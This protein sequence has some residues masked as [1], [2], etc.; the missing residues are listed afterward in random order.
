MSFLNAAAF[1]F[2]A[3]IPVVVVLYLL[4]RKRTY[5]AVSST[6]LWQRFL[7]ETQASAPFQK[8][9]YHWLL[10]IQILLLI[11]AVL[12]L[13]RPALSKGGASAPLRV[14]VLDG[15]A[16]MQATDESPSRFEKARAQALEMAAS[17]RGAERMMI[18]LAGVRAEVLQSPTSDKAALRR[19]LLGC[20]PSD[21][22]TRLADALKTAAAFTFERRRQTDASGASVEAEEAF[23]EIHLFSDGA[24]SGLEEF[25]TR[26]LPLVWHRVGQRCENLGVVSL[27][28]RP[29]PDDPARRA[30]FVGIRNPGSN[31]MQAAVELSFE[32]Q[33]L[34][35]K[36]VSVPPGTTVPLVFFAAQSR[37]GVFTARLNTPGRSGRRQPGQRVEP[38]PRRPRASCWSPAATGSSNAPC[39]AP[40]A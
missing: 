3:A 35:T 20:Q 15:S 26:A 28:A 17:L 37:D 34:E 14:V 11:L 6:I 24:A 36:P 10:A 16:S 7:A 8:L 22:P 9:R 4:K 2:A 29:H 13:S 32:N 23:G 27:E 31:E 39:A 38:A 5:Q 21:T 40:A 19:A 30:V 12:A 18:L 1:A 25:E 33:P